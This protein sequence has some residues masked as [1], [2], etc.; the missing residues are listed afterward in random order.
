VI[1]FF[2]YSK[3]NTKMREKRFDSKEFIDRFSHR[4]RNILYQKL[5]GL[6]EIQKED[7][8][9]E[10]KLKIWKMLCKGR[11]IKNL[12]S[13]LW[14]V[15]YTTAL[16]M[17]EEKTQKV[18]SVFER[19]DYENQDFEIPGNDPPLDELI[20]KRKMSERLMHEI[21]SLGF[22]QRIVIK[23][24]LTG[25]NIREISEFLDWSNSKV[26]HIFYRGLNKLK[27]KNNEQTSQG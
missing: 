27:A 17:I 6:N 5:P 25:R 23:L 18:G 4:I 10:V 2:L 1:A 9:Q 19:V 15:V 8:E 26:N 24:Y 11:K 21:N 20:E 16:D 22:E 12:K 13:Y 3:H 14:R 7:I